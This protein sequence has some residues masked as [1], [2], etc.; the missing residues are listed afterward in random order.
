MECDKALE[1]MMRALDGELP[2]E[3][4]QVLGAHLELCDRCRVRWEQLQAAEGVLRSAPI[5]SPPPG[6]VGRVMAQVDRRRARRRAFFGG[7]ALVAGTTLVLFIGLLP[8]FW[9]LPG[10]AGFLMA[11]SRS[12]DVLL[13]HALGAAHL[14]LNSLGLLAG[15]LVIQALPLALCS[16]MTA[17]FLGGLWWSLLRRWQPVSS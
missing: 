9:T 8:I 11:L 13:S 12:G 6:F 1:Q 3:E 17:L 16:L 10:W 5:L 2:D 7:L 4:W 14:F 15:A